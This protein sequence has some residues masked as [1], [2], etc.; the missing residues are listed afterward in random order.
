MQIYPANLTKVLSDGLHPIYVICGNDVALEMDVRDEIVEAAHQ[1]GISDFEVSPLSESASRARTK[2]VDWNGL[3]SDVSE[4]SLFAA[5]KIVEF[6][7]RASA[8]NDQGINTLASHAE[9]K[10][11]N[12]LLVRIVS[13]ENRDKRKSWY[14]KV[15]SSPDIPF[16]VADELNQRELSNWLKGKLKKLD[17]TLTEDAAQ[18]LTELCEGNLLAIRQELDKFALIFE[19]GST[20]E[21]K[22]IELRDVSNADMLEL[23]DAVFSGQTQL[24]VKR[25]DALKRQPKSSARSELAILNMVAQTLTLA[26]SVSFGDQAKISSFQRRRVDQICRTHSPRAIEAL[27]FE[28]AQYNSMFLGM[29]RGDAWIHLQSLLLAVAGVSTATLENEYR[30]REIDRRAN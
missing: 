1:V 17:I 14:K 22:D 3:V 24:I 23:V 11:Q 26:Q 16:I 2:T 13:F 30:W 6:Q 10:S 19:P 9:S 25:M 27:L 18:K 15:R 20:V 7:V 8:L 21:E 12:L 29:A 5:R 28:C 4:S